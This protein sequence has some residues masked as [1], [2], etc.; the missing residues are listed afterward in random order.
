MF[1]PKTKMAN[2]CLIPH[3]VFFDRFNSNFL[4]GRH[5]WARYLYKKRLTRHTPCLGLGPIVLSFIV[6]MLLICSGIHPNPG[7]VNVMDHR[8]ISICHVNIRSLKHIDE[9]GTRDKLMH[10]KCELASKFKII[11]LSKTWLSGSD[12]SEDYRLPG[13]QEPFRRDRDPNIGAVGYGGVLAWISNKI[14]CKRRRDLELP[15]IEAMW[16]KVRS[17]SKKFFLCI[18]YRAPSNANDIFWEVF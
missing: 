6:Q 15:D 10:I 5:E 13:F 17:V 11:T 1:V 14:A 18:V 7:P 9:F 3:G 12:S 8:D 4:I 16:L 2:K